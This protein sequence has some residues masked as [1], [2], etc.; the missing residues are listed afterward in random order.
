MRCLLAGAI[1]PECE[2]IPWFSGVGVAK[3]GNSHK[4]E[5]NNIYSAR[6]ETK[7][8]SLVTVG[9]E[10]Q[11]SVTSGPHYAIPKPGDGLHVCLLS[12]LQRT[13]LL[14]LWEHREVRLTICPMAHMYH[15]KREVHIKSGSGEDILKEICSSLAVRTPYYSAAGI[16]WVQGA[17]LLT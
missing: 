14:F 1:V 17:F 11:S 15:Q 2:P 9:S 16:F 12:C 10:C 3:K 5:W 4:T 7:Q 6:E 8:V 13:S